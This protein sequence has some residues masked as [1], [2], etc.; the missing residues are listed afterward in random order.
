M[1]PSSGLRL[2]TIMVK[3]WGLAH[4]IIHVDKLQVDMIGMIFTQ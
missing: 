4:I 2:D 3:L 1:D